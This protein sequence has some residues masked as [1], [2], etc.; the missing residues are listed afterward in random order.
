MFGWLLTFLAIASL[1]V[2][3]ANTTYTYINYNNSWNAGT[4]PTNAPVINMCL[5]PFVYISSGIWGSVPVF[6]VGIISLRIAMASG[7][8]RCFQALVL[9]CALVFAPAMIVINA[10]EVAAGNM[11]PPYYSIASNGITGDITKFV[12]P[13]V[14]AALAAIEFLILLLMLCYLFMNRGAS[15]TGG[16]VTGG[17]DMGGIDYGGDIGGDAGYGD[18][19][20]YADD[21][22]D[23]GDGG[24]GPP[25]P[26]M[27]YPGGGSGGGGGGSGGG[28]AAGGASSS[29]A[30]GTSGGGGASNN[31]NNNNI[32][33]PPVIFPPAPAAA[34][35]M[36]PFPIYIPQGGGGG[37][38]VVVTTTS[39]PA[40]PMYMPQP[41][42]PAPQP[43]FLPLPAPVRRRPL[44][45]RPVLRP[46]PPTRYYPNR[47]LGEVR[48]YAGAT[49]YMSGLD[50]P[51]SGKPWD[52][53]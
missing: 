9:I 33:V 28:A 31:N 21:M 4:C 47:R 1:S 23:P 7:L 30:G 3:I 16:Y 51:F 12:L 6:I 42:A 14:V 25:P 13:L 37:N 40:G 17:V 26:P 48:S 36:M 34:P 46:L 15:Y 22:F 10:I 43:I 38:P 35:Q 50:S 2:A 27:M 18:D 5:V 52:R 20:G 49:N 8:L 11:L 32:V 19:L 39:N 41:A 53:Y 24:Y 44:P 29:A 45:P